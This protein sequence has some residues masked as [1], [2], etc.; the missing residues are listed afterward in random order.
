MKIFKIVVSNE[1]IQD[2]LYMVRSLIVVNEKLWFLDAR[3]T[4]APK[5]T[6]GF[7][8]ETLYTIKKRAKDLGFAFTNFYPLHSVKYK[9]IALY[10]L[11]SKTIFHMCDPWQY[12]PTK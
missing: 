2:N 11:K 1:P 4:M 6:W 9:K 12:R 5:S 8:M 3:G 7:K 10:S